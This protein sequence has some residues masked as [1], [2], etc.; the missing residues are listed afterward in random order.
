MLCEK[1]REKQKLQWLWKDES[2]IR[3]NGRDYFIFFSSL[4][5]IIHHLCIM[6][7]YATMYYYVLYATA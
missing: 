2:A 3:D 5:F 7:Y 1:D 4:S 6:N